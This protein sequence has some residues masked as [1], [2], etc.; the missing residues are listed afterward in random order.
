MTYSL[1]P[2]KDPDHYHYDFEIDAGP[3]KPVALVRVPATPEGR[4]LAETLTLA[5]EALDTI[6]LLQESRTSMA[7]WAKARRVLILAGR[8]K[9]SIADYDSFPEMPPSEFSAMLKRGGP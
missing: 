8:R 6:A 4:Q 1:R 5:K 7:A 2:L 3:G 9:P